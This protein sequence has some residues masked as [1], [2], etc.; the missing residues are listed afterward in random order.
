MRSRVAFCAQKPI[1]GNTAFWFF[2]PNSKCGNSLWDLFEAR[3]KNGQEISR[4][5]S[6]SGALPPAAGAL[7]AQG[8]PHALDLAECSHSRSGRE[9][10]GHRAKD[11]VEQ[12]T[13]VPGVRAGGERGGGPW[14]GPVLTAGLWA[15]HSGSL[16]APGRL[17][18]WQ[19]CLMREMMSLSWCCHPGAG[20]QL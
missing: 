20:G 17:P 9:G 18:S 8:C 15:P 14:A 13:F 7:L 10:Q 5:T 2:N 19:G 1:F 6:V 4:V 16:E 12:R 3:N 11:T